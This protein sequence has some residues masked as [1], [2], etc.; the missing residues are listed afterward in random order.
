PATGA[1]LPDL[2]A[3]GVPIITQ[4]VDGAFCSIKFQ[5]WTA[6]LLDGEAGRYD[7]EAT[8]SEIEQD[9]RVV[10]RLDS[11][12]ASL[13]QPFGNGNTHHPGDAAHGSEKSGMRGE[14]IDTQIKKRAATPFVKPTGPIRPRPT[15]AAPCGND[16]ANV[17][18]TK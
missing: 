16:P 15:V 14:I 6:I 5:P 4:Q 12:G 11:L 17:A 7:G 2:V 9:M 13:N 3:V 1:I 10:V 18:A 8:A